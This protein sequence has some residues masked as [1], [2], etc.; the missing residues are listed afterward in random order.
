MRFS[1]RFGRTLPGAVLAVA[2]TVAG[3]SP[4]PW[5]G[6]F[7][8]PSSHTQSGI[9]APTGDRIY[10]GM[11]QLPLPDGHGP[12]TLEDVQLT[13]G[14]AGGEVHVA[15]VG[16]YLLSDGMVGVTRGREYPLPQTSEVRGYVVRPE[17]PVAVLFG[18]DAVASGNW[19][20]DTVTV[21][22]QR[23][24][25]TAHQSLRYSFGFCVDVAQADECDPGRPA[26][27]RDDD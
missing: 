7:E 17:Q 23:G 10:W 13:G 12:V 6:P 16:I 4:S 5:D 15:Q 3:C 11:A 25:H 14:A 8:Q 24:R 26:W 27:W 1:M 18:L 19:R 2:L 9:A 22:Y 20:A 21:T